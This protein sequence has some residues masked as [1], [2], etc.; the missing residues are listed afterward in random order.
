MGY[1]KV[2]LWHQPY[3]FNHDLK[4][5]YSTINSIEMKADLFN[6]LKEL[7]TAISNLPDKDKSDAKAILAE[8]AE[9]TSQFNR[10]K[11]QHGPRELDLQ[12]NDLVELTNIINE[13][14]QTAAIKHL[15][16]WPK[17]V[18]DTRKGA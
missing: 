17:P 2:F 8:A 12:G 10:G 1:E 15:E 3:P 5:L 9:I 11:Y 6:R 16:V 13:I 18:I 14:W 4:C 7:K